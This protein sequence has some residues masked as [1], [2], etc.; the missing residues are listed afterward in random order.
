MFLG[1]LRLRHFLPCNLDSESGSSDFFS[2]LQQQQHHL[3]P[4]F[5][6]HGVPDIMVHCLFATSPRPCGFFCSDTASFAGSKCRNISSRLLTNPSANLCLQKDLYCSSA[7]RRYDLKRNQPGHH[8]SRSDEEVVRH[9]ATFSRRRNG[10]HGRPGSLPHALNTFGMGL[11]DVE[12]MG[13]GN[14]MG[15]KSMGDERGQI[16]G[17]CCGECCRTGTGFEATAPR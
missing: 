11:E 2:L 5:T 4:N 16:D 14:G 8:R 13:P 17:E 7:C 9:A 1:L 6:K 10:R 15:S 3:T 12:S